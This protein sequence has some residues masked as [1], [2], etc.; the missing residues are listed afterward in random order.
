MSWHG[1]GA[2]HR[3]E[4]EIVAQAFMKY[5]ELKGLIAHVEQ[6][7]SET[8]RV[9]LICCVHQQDLTTCHLLLCSSHIERYRMDDT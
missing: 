2:K 7:M 3:R 5:E 1:F 9:Q 4:G 6:L 8:K